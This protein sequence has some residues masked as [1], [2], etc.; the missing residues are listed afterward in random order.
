MRRAFIES[1]AAIRGEA[2]GLHVVEHTAA[3]AL[4]LQLIG[5]S[6]A[7]QQAGAVAAA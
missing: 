2:L 6:R 5:A 3:G 7:G 4:D 1:L